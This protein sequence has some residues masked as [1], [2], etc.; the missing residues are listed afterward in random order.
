M[1]RKNKSIKIVL[2][3]L[4]L[5]VTFGFQKKQTD[6]FTFTD[7]YGNKISISDVK[8]VPKIIDTSF[9]KNNLSGRY[10]TFKL[11]E[12]ADLKFSY[13][14]AEFVRINEMEYRLRISQKPISDVPWD[15]MRYVGFSNYK[16]SLKK[17]EN[18]MKIKNL[19]FMYTEL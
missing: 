19:K 5:V 7:R 6:E 14:I 3:Q 13:T 9:L 4:L 2:I 10:F 1:K 12:Y 17:T 15:D 18:G 16:L 8:M 11:K